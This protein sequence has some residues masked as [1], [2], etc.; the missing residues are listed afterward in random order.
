MYC[1]HIWGS[2]CSRNLQRLYILQKKA[3]RIICNANPRSHSAPLFKDLKLLN[4][5]QMNKFLIGQ[6][7]YKCYHKTLPSLF[8]SYFVR[9]HDVH[10]HN[11]RQA[12][13][14]YKL[15]ITRTNYC[16]INIRFRAPAIW[17]DIIRNQVSPDVSICTFKYKVKHLLLNNII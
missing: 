7:M 1:N 6:F 13:L 11:T 14:Y 4:I 3:I 16:K 8:D 17:N 9:V 12:S 2:S 5:W 15:P 10:N